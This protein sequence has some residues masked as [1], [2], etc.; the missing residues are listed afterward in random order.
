MSVLLAGDVLNLR[1]GIYVG[2]VNIAGKHGTADDPIVIRSFPGEHAYIDGTLDEFRRPSNDDW[3]PASSLHEEAV[4]DEYV[5]AMTFTDDLVNRGAF[6]DRNPYTRLVTYSNINDLRADNE[7]FEQIF[8][9][10]DP[11]PGP[12]VTDEDGNPLGYRR[13]WVYMGPGIHFNADTRRVHVRLS[14]THNNVPGIIDYADESDPR[15]VPLAITPRDVTA[16]RIGGSSHLRLERLTISF[17]GDDSILITSS[18]NLTLDHVRIRAATRGIRMGGPPQNPTRNVVFAHCQFDGGIP[19]WYFRTDRKSVYHFLDGDRVVPNNL[20]ENT[21]D[22]LLLG[23]PNNT[24]VEIHHCEFFN[25]HDIFLEGQDVDFHHNWINNLQDDG[26]A[27]GFDER[28]SGPV[29]VTKIHEN[30]I[31]KTLTGFSFSSRN[32]TTQWHIYRNLIDQRGPTRGFR[33]RHVGDTEV[34]RYGQLHKSAGNTFGPHDLFHNTVLAYDQREQA[35]FLHYASTTGR[36]RRRSF[37]NVFV[38]VNPETEAD[39]AI[40][41]V[42]SPAF[43]GPTDGNLYHRIGFAA[44]D[45]FRHVGYRFQGQDFPG[46]G[47]FADLEEL[48]NSVLFEQSK[49]QYPPGY[50]ANSLLADPQVRRISADGRP[51]ENDDLR[52]GETSP[53]LAAGIRLPDELGDLDPFPPDT[54]NP[55]IGCYPRNA[56][57]FRVGVDGCRSFPQEPG[58]SVSGPRR[59]AGGVWKS[60]FLHEFLDGDPANLHAVPGELSV[61]PDGPIIQPTPAPADRG[62]LLT[63]GRALGYRF[64]EPFEDVIGV[65]LSVDLSV[66]LLFPPQIPFVNNFPLVSLGDG[67]VTLS[68]HRVPTPSFA[69]GIRLSVDGSSMQFDEFHTVVMPSG[70]TNRLRVRWHTH[71]QAQIWHEGVLRAYEPGFAAGRSFEIDRLVVGRP[72]EPTP[73]SPRFRARRVYLKLLRR[74]D[75]RH[76]I[77]RHVPLDVSCF[78]A[79]Q[80]A[81]HVRVLHEELVSRARAFMTGIVSKLTTSWREGQAPGPFSPESIA[82]HEAAVG[83]AEAFGAFLDTREQ[84]A[85]NTFLQRIG[86]FFDILATADPAGFAELVTD[87]AQHAESVD[88]ACRRT[89]EPVYAANADAL[90][91]LE[92][93]LQA[94][95]QR[96]QTARPGGPNA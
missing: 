65:D 30:V 29:T 25:A 13:P 57:P 70:Q 37:N 80:C 73:P 19:S 55:D 68:I 87:L 45:P 14:H 8:D 48:H 7:T 66:E 3:I 81:E 9:E 44:N 28:T 76:E 5:S 41:F 32:Q 43:P 90:Q 96:A 39:R 60:V 11:R 85:A 92:L 88:P 23:N 61:L 49:T 10:N 77:D 52:L 95:W 83:A 20:G 18:Q 31:T 27:L 93:L 38:A 47:T 89:L 56:E 42:P 6:L 62:F 79:D 59:T 53:A 21:S 26:L 82:A 12:A 50:E 2:P 36:H 35:S 51:R 67:T 16:L 74:D 71:G 15:R 84:A 1:H 34:W 63:P 22:R 69:V 72:G 78:P 17:G 91:P 86:E 64:E 33:P 4:D 46:N 58:P 24:A 54:G 94:A 40:T 75:A